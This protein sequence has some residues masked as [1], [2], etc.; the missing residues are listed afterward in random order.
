MDVRTREHLSTRAKISFPSFIIQ[1]LSPVFSTP[2]NSYKHRANTS[3]GTIVDILILFPGGKWHAEDS[4][5][6]EENHS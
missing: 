2:L 5:L 1:F 4:S 3:T 6:P